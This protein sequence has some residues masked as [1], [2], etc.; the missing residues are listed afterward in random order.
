MLLAKTFSLPQIKVNLEKYDNFFTKKS[1]RDAPLDEPDPQTIET[2]AAV[3]LDRRKKAHSK[4]LEI[5]DR[6]S[7]IR[8][9]VESFLTDS[10]KMGILDHNTNQTSNR[11]SL[12]RISLEAMKP[13]HTSSEQLKCY[14]M[15]LKTELNRFFKKSS[16]DK[17]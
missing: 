8:S 16:P 5:I 7:T 4:N 1:S 13:L 10:R 12:T 15:Q 6:K 17:R 11:R 9:K 14:L 2:E 3:I